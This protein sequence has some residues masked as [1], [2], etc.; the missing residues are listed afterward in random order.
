MIE[1]KKKLKNMLNLIMILLELILILERGIRFYSN[2]LLFTSLLGI[3]Y[4]Y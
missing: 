1:K 3:L 4:K 2:I